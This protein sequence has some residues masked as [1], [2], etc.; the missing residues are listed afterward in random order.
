MRKALTFRK[1]LIRQAGMNMLHQRARG[2]LIRYRWLS[3]TGSNETA[4]L[5]SFSGL[6][7]FFFRRVADLIE[8]LRNPTSATRVQVPF[9]FFARHRQALRQIRNSTRMFIGCLIWQPG[10]FS[11]RDHIQKSTIFLMTPF[12]KQ[13]QNKFLKTLYLN[14]F[15]NLFFGLKTFFDE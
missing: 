15:G 1:E 14:P 8:G 5:S 3:V 4:A 13:K 2:M 12:K 7:F 10:H 9:A 11:Y 6:D